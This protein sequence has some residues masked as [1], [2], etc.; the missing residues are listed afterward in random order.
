[1]IDAAG[2]GFFV[3]ALCGGW[4]NWWQG[5]SDSEF[6]EH[7]RTE[8]P[9]IVEA[10]EVAAKE[11][12]FEITTD[13]SQVDSCDMILLCVGEIPYAEWLGDTKTLSLTGEQGMSQNASA[14]KFAQDSGKPTVTLIVAGRNVIIDDYIDQ[15]DS[16]QGEGQKWYIRPV[17]EQYTFTPG[18]LNGDDVVDIISRDMYPPAHEHTS[19]KEFYHNLM[20]ITEEPK[21]V[22]IGETG[23]LPSAK[24][25]VDEH[26]GWASYMTWSHEFCTSEEYTTKE[27]LK[28]MYN[29][30]Y[31]VTKDTLPK[32]Y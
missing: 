27:V 7:F 13:K 23:T 32:L 14:I 29:S 19:Q 25:V 20:K 8:G 1:M 10:L 28:E 2:D 15:W 16:W 4:T 6:G 22:L 30:P 12:G 9:S 5:M 11:G 21:I 24:A 3:G 26:I 18:D 31:S 17:Q